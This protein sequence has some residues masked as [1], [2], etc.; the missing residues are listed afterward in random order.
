MY[1][2]KRGSARKRG[3]GLCLA[4]LLCLGSFPQLQGA[5]TAHAAS[6]DDYIGTNNLVDVFNWQNTTNFSP[7]TH[8]IFGNRYFLVDTSSYTP[9]PGVA[10]LNYASSSL[11]S[12]VE[13]SL[14]A[15][16]E[17]S[18]TFDISVHDPL[19]A[20]S[21]AAVTLAE[22]PSS[23]KKF[24]YLSVG[25]ANDVQGLLINR[26]DFS[27]PNANDYVCLLYTSSTARRP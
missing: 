9:Y 16:W 3:L 24:I 27:R 14:E 1:K 20:L 15:D 17:L 8:G 2:Q 7:S 25:K 26:V 4:V 13:I 10:T 12:K 23:A 11:V 22:N 5:G 19:P 6:T 18:G 21:N